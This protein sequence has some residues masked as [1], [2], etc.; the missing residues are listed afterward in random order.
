MSRWNFLTNHGHILFLIALSPQI[1]I[2]EISLQVGITERAVLKIISDLTKDEYIEVKKEGRKNIYH[3]FEE[4]HLCHELEK[5]C[6]VKDLISVI[7]NKNN[8]RAS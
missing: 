4:K 8:A 3:I 6:K 7:K 5:H 2:R 1:T